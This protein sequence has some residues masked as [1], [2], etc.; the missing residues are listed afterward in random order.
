MFG[1]LRHV[2]ATSIVVRPGAIL[3]VVPSAR[4]LTE[5]PRSSSGVA[6]SCLCDRVNSSQFAV[7][8]VSPTAVS[9]PRRE[10]FDA[11]EPGEGQ[12]RRARS[13]RHVPG[14]SSMYAYLRVVA[15]PDQGRI[16]NLVDGTTLSIGRA[17]NSDTR[18]K[19]TTACRL[20]CELRCQGSDFQ[21]VDLESVSGT[22][23]DGQKIQERA[24]RHGEEFQ[25]GNTRLKLFSSAIGQ[26][27]HLVEAQKLEE[28]EKS[29][30]EL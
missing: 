4:R 16:F 15:G 17:E 26:T 6:Q 10:P 3:S 23:V 19:D 2:R 11:G 28:V 12:G 25:V 29:A 27:Q 1:E 22:F 20:H 24:L 21:L 14:G 8:T 5:P 30:Y 7:A 13:R 9:R 18:L